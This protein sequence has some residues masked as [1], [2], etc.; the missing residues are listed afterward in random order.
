MYGLTGVNDR[1]KVKMANRDRI[2]WKGA[3]QR[4]W[5]ENDE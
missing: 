5:F 2:G 4:I 1:G 3:G